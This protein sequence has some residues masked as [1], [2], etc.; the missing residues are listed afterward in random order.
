M[1]RSVDQ[2][3]KQG[4]SGKAVRLDQCTGAD[5]LKQR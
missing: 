5:A 4:S 2:E 3:S 1:K